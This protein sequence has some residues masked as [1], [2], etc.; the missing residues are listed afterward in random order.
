MIN[1]PRRIQ[2]KRTKGWRMP[3]GAVYVGRPTKWGNPYPVMQRNNELF[4]REDSVRMFMEGCSAA[5]HRLNMVVR[6]TA[7][8]VSRSPVTM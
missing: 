2:R 1:E 3:E 4:S 7:L 6:R 8:G 5:N